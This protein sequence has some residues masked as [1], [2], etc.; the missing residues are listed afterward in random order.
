MHHTTP[1]C[2]A[3]RT[4][5]QSVLVSAQATS[6]PTPCSRCLITPEMGSRTLSRRCGYCF[7]RE[8][9]GLIPDPYC[10]HLCEVCQAL[11]E[12]NPGV[13]GIQR[14]E[15]L[16]AMWAARNA[17]NGSNALPAVFGVASTSLT[18]YGFLWDDAIN[19]CWPF[20]SHHV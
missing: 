15:T 16:G 17:R 14:I 7:Q 12:E 2:I 5:A 13:I 9:I 10:A 11:D 8:G 4:Q 6:P 3:I 1:L 19:L 20:C 18:I